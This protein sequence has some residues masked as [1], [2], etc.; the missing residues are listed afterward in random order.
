MHSGTAIKRDFDDISDSQDELAG[1]A[2]RLE[3][4]GGESA[5]PRVAMEHEKRIRREI[6]N[7]NERRRMQSI[8]AGFQALRSLLPQH[9]GEKLSK[10]AILQ[11]TS[12]FIYSLEQEK[13]RLL[14]Q[15][16]QLKRLLGQQQQAGDSDAASATDSPASAH[17]NAS[18]ESAEAPAPS[19][20]AAAA[21]AA[22]AEPAAPPPQEA[23]AASI[24]QEL[25]ELRA[26]LEQE[27]R[28]RLLTEDRLRLA[29]AP[30]P[31]PPAT[32][33]AERLHAGHVPLL[34]PKVEL[35]E[36]PLEPAEPPLTGHGLEP[37]TALLLAGRCQPAGA[38]LRAAAAA[39]STAARGT[40]PAQVRRRPDSAVGARRVPLYVGS[41]TSRQNLDTIVEA[42]RHLEGDHLFQDLVPAP[43]P[44]L[45]VE[46]CLEEPEPQDA[47][48]ELTTHDRASAAAAAS[49]PYRPGVI[50]QQQQ[51]QQQLA[52]HLVHQRHLPS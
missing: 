26:Q 15:N 50:V 25:S 12:D 35:V 10:A 39:A 28:H 1:S 19:E 32:P 20:E 8:N 30:P 31:P 11:Q 34:K 5:P 29:E 13:A 48:L 37:Q 18:R 14:T 51:Q 41:A 36:A 42:I 43:E 38:A 2:C 16:C 24:R 4:S 3:D 33:F 52:H 6:A 47:P 7:S 21:P 9:E 22:P 49:D 44:A 23:E 45:E 40:H 17:R 46:A 27:R